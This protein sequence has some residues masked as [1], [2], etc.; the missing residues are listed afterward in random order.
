MN[1]IA[2]IASKNEVWIIENCLKIIDKFCDVILISD[3]NSTDGSIEVYKKFKKVRLV[4]Q[5]NVEIKGQNRRSILL[6]ESRKIP[7]ENILFFLDSDEL[8]IL[9]YNFD[10]NQYISNLNKGDVI[11]VPWLWLWKSTE[12]YRDDKSV[13]SN[14][15]LPFIFYDDKVSKYE[16]GDWH[17]SRVPGNNHNTLRTNLTSL[18]H[19]ATVSKNK[20]ESR[21]RY[22]MIKEYLDLKKDYPSINLTYVYTIDENDIVLKKLNS[23][24]LSDWEEIGVKLNFSIE[25]EL[26]WHDIEILKLFNIHG[27]QKFYNLNIWDINWEFKRQLAIGID[28]IPEFQIQDNRN[29]EQRLYHYFLKKNIQNPFWRNK[30]Y[31]QYAFS[32]ILKKNLPQTHSFLKRIYGNFFLR[33]T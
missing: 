2:L 29:L 3:G 27:L 12:H 31:F 13:W 32:S 24:V 6:E 17:E 1:K 25:E 11:E 15:W 33:K 16:M 23:Q 5:H 14:R 18:V 30:Y 9:P 8:P 22:C 28:G 7:G 26:N 19:F 4:E 21:Q 10:F 20:F